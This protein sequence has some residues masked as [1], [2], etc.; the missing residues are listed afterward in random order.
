MGS[1]LSHRMANQL[2]QMVSSSDSMS[3]LQALTNPR[4]L[5]RPDTRAMIPPE[6][7]PAVQHALA[8]GLEGAFVIGFVA[9]CGGLV[10]SLMMPNKTPLEHGNHSMVELE[11]GRAI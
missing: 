7:L 3:E 8:Y 10:F 4:L 6:H 5:L 2:A 1:I 11:E 9:A